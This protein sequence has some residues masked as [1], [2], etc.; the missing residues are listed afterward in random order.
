MFLC[1]SFTD[2]LT[3]P[4]IKMSKNVKIITRKTKFCLFRVGVE[5]GLVRYAKNTER[6]FEKGLLRGMSGPKG[7]KCQEAEEG[8]KVIKRRRARRAR[9]TEHVPAE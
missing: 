1:N 7:M 9:H 4:L 5:P 6:V 3:V 2:I 8:I